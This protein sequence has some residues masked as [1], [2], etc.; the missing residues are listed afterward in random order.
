MFDFYFTFRTITAAQRAAYALMQ[1]GLDAEFVRTPKALSSL[2]CGYAVRVNRSDATLAGML[3]RRDGI[4]YE[5]GVPLNG[6][7]GGRA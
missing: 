7:S 3:F 1:Y 4:R 5:R 6:G 2:G